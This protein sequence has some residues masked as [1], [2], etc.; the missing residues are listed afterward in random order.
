[1]S[2]KAAP[3]E[4][5]PQ[6]R[7]REAPDPQAGR[8]AGNAGAERKLAAGPR[9]EP[10]LA[11]RWSFRALRKAGN[12]LFPPKGAVQIISGS[13]WVCSFITASSASSSSGAA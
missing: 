10:R 11:G 1:M 12:R 4:L 9:S 13:G 5:K 3:Q 8:E 6:D 7:A 2:G